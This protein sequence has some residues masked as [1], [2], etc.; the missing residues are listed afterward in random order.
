MEKILPALELIVSA[1]FGGKALLGGTI[2]FTVMKALTTGFN[3]AVFATDAGTGIVPILQSSAKTKHPV[4]D[5]VVTLI[6]PFLVMIVCTSTVLVLMVTGAWQAVGLQ[7]TNMVMHAFDVGLGVGG[8]L[9]TY[10]VLIS[11]FLFGY[12]TTLAY[13]TCLDRAVGFL[14]GTRFIRFFQLLYIVLVPAGALLKVGFVWLVADITLTSMLVM[15]LI[16]ILGLSKE[17]IHETRA[18][19][20]RPLEAEPAP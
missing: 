15:N 6:T 14:F 8:K 9:G 13:A 10:I 16:G 1:A 12:T 19:F 20:S 5:G 3:R 7:S 2:G 18:Y 11:L 17:V 4:V